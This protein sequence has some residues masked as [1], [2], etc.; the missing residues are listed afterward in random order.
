[1][2]RRAVREI[3]IALGIALTVAAAPAF[4]DDYR[5]GISDRLKIK[6][7]EWPDL[8]GEYAVTPDGSVSLPLIGNVDAAGLRIKDIAQ[9]ISDRLQRRAEGAERP[10]AAIEIIQFRPFSIVGD[11]QRPG[12]QLGI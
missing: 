7:Q 8:N 11:V 12:R 2:T 1:M 5:L 6:V 3:T 10:L 4:G 9:D